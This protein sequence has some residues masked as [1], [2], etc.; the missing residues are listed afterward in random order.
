[1]PDRLTDEQVRVYAASSPE[2]D[3][4]RLLAQDL[5]DARAERDRARELLAVLHGDGGHH[6][7]AVGFRQAAED[8]E[9]AFHEQAAELIRA[10]KLLDELGSPEL[11]KVNRPRLPTVMCPEGHSIYGVSESHPLPE[12]WRT[13][14]CP[15]CGRDREPDDDENW[16]Q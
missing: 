7:D 14:G 9:A 10:R 15:V 12:Y 4:H 8:A 3:S 5:L 6:I 1:M 13:M 16:L 11:R 2:C